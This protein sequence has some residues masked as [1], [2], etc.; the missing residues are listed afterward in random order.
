MDFGVLLQGLLIGFS[1]SVPVGP[2]GVLVI[3][4]TLAEGFASGLT[5]GVG[6]A[7]GMALYGSVIGFGL[8]AISDLLVRYQRPF[9]IVGGLFL[10]YLGYT[11]VRAAPPDPTN[12]LQRHNLLGA[13]ASTFALTIFSPAVILYFLAILT[14]S[15]L[16]D[17]ERSY[18]TALVLILGVFLGALG[19]WLTLSGAVSLLRARLNARILRW[20]NG[21]SGLAI[22]AFGVKVA[23]GL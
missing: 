21:F 19:W 17:R 15:D 7:S 13:Y 20:A 6:C 18:A 2:V 12:P 9:A 16:L 14:S 5:S 4:R 8:T 1:I 11:I 10:I 22:A 3:R 23:L